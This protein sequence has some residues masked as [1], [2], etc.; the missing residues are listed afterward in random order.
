MIRSTQSTGRGPDAEGEQ[1]R[2]EDGLAWTH[3]ARTGWLSDLMEG[4]STHR[5]WV[6]E[7]EEADWVAAQ[8]MNEV[9]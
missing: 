9:C 3:V 6:Q 1:G 8:A 5:E 2:L 4:Q 7:K